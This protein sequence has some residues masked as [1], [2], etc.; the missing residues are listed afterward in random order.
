M[1]PL[2]TL[3]IFL[4]A[5]LV[6]GVQP[7]AARMLLPSFGGSPAVWSATSVFFQV[8]L[9][10][11]YGYS[12]V[13]TRSLAP[14]RQPLVHLVALAAPLAFL[15]LSL[16]LLTGGGTDPAFTVIGLLAVGLGV[17][18]TIASTTG[19]LL[20]RWF[21]YTGHPSG[22]D[23]YFLY[24][25]SNAGSLLVLLS[26]PFLIEPRL[27]LTEQSA[28]WSIGYALF[29]VLSAICAATVIR[30][31]PA[32]V[33]AD[34]DADVI[35]DVTAPTWRT[36]GRWVVLAAVP[37][38]L[39]LGATAYISTDIA[40][41]PLLWIA[42][43]SLYLLSFILAFSTRIPITSRHAGRLLP[44]A[45]AAVVIPS[46]GLLDLS[47]PVVIALHLVF[48]F[49]A[50]TMCHTRLAEERPAP[51][52][53]TEFYLLVAVGG[54]VGGIFVSIIAPAIFDRVWEYPIAIG[55]ALLLRPAGARLLNRR[56]LTGAALV[57]AVTL[58]VG[59][60]ALQQGGIPA[61]VGPIAITSAL[62][63]SFLAL[64]P[65]RPVLAL[66]AFGILAVTVW[67]SGTAIHTERTFFGVYRVTMSGSDHLLVHGSTVHGLQHREPSRTR[68]PSAYYHRTGPIGQLFAARGDELDQV[69]V[70]GLGVG[71][72]AAYSEPGQHFTFY[73]IDSAMVDI[74][75]DP[76]LFTFLA[77]AGGDMEVVVAD[78]RLGLAA[79]DRAYDLV[80]LDAFTSDAIPV[81][82]L[83]REAVAGY[84]ER[85]SP[86]GVI[87]INISNR[88][89]DLEPAVAA[90]ARSL[91]MTAVVQHDADVTD[92]ERAE[93][94]TPSS[95]M[96]IAPES[97][98]LDAFGAESRWETARIDEDVGPWSDAFSDILAVLR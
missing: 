65:L 98:R 77:D 40:A 22:R 32:E 45:A 1:L 61:A 5:V 23:P 50:A 15:P 17:P 43:L 34:P 96:I 49:V 13:V 16:P 20:Q 42:P 55:L 4:G 66:A 51:F 28:T 62:L 18:F 94:K 70:L 19:P 41:V 91:D 60:L 69:A 25:A 9:L 8:A 7:I 93:G 63:V 85:L 71:T 27:D 76:A 75:R 47:T 78:G 44:L 29:A 54:A 86:D 67:G 24:A 80:I 92:E 88:F 36:R 53:L 48:L 68:V 52:R 2:F 39:S 31:T 56:G 10:L 6:F 81:H 87:A 82:L 57:I 73:E 84:A 58:A 64:A 74:A 79:D 83:T 14:R 3:T 38:A 90:V 12:F 33:P 26:Y 95:W 35:A 11:G 59:G 46:G 89:L 21:S 97:S 37:S 30:R 72:L